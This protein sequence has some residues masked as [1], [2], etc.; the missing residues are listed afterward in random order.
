MIFIQLFVKKKLKLLSFSKFLVV[1][2]IKIIKWL[3]FKI[4][5]GYV[6]FL[7]NMRE[8]MRKRK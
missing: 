1:V 4:P 2:F 3:F 5:L 8:N 7:E 6:G